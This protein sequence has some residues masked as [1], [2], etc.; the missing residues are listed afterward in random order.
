M[1][2]VEKLSF[3]GIVTLV[4]MLIVFIVLIV[5]M[6]VIK[7]QSKIL[8]S[9]VSDNKNKVK[10]T[11]EEKQEIKKEDNVVIIEEEVDLRDDYELVAAIMGALCAETGSSASDLRIKSIKR[12]ENNNWNRFSL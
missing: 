7:L 8:T 1:S 12:I 2:F 4:S 10:E 9:I 5:L 11:K 3:S 6:F